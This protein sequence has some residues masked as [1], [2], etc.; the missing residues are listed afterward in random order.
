MKQVKMF[1]D[2][3]ND[4]RQNNYSSKISA[5][6]YEPKNLN[7]H[8]LELCDKEKTNRL[9][10]EINNS[11]LLIDEKKFLIDAAYRHSVFN[12][13]KIADY[14]S[15]ATLEMQDLMEKSALV[16]I[17]FEKAIQYGFVKLNESIKEMHLTSYENE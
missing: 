3:F 6:V 14:Y 13:Q 11:N 10:R 12:Y 7:P 2:E 8:I 4:N 5:P 16:I 9:I 1:G 15:H 17:D